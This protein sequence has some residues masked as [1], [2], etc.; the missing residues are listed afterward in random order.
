MMKQLFAKI[1]KDTRV[2]RLIMLVFLIG[3]GGMA[4]NTTYADGRADALMEKIQSVKQDYQQPALDAT[5]DK[6]WKN[7]P[8]KSGQ[9]VNVEKSYRA[10]K[11]EAKFNEKKL[12]FD[13]IKPGITLDNL[14]ADVIYRGNPKKQ[15]IALSINVAWGEAYIPQMLDILEEQ[16]V[17]ATFY[18]EGR[19][20]KNHTKLVKQMVKAGHEIGNH[21]YTHADFSSIST[22]QARDELMK[23]NQVLE[24]IT[25][26]KIQ[27]FAP[28]SGAFNG[29]TAQ[30]AKELGMYT[31]LWTM[32]TIDW[33]NPSP[34]TVMQR[35]LKKKHPGGIVLMHPTKAS[36]YALDLMIETLQGKGYALGTVG[37]LI[38]I[39]E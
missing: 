6:V 27:L 22:E 25:K 34:S 20:A 29:E 1:M 16:G 14:P 4:V 3:I 21:S 24:K 26:K 12:V 37:S 15:R 35:I 23:T 10:M 31:I 36:T 28:P 17:Y 32:D 13:K 33:Q 30:L 11:K 18:I 2:Y 9:Q 19:W 7:V 8:G 39:E 5:S 38:E